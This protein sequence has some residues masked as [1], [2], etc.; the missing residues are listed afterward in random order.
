LVF[1]PDHDESVTTCSSSCGSSAK[2]LNLVHPHFQQV[3]NRLATTYHGGSPYFLCCYERLCKKLHDEGHK[4]A[5]LIGLPLLSMKLNV[6][7]NNFA[8]YILGET[9]LSRGTITADIYFIYVH[10]IYRGRGYATI[11]Y[12]TFENLVVARSVKVGV[13]SVTL[14]VTL[15]ECILSGVLFWKKKDFEGSANSVCLIKQLKCYY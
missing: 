2:L 14:R 3:L 6:M 10:N 15:K 5:I 13:K 1:E 4:N 9:I 12:D 11:L 8:G 7:N